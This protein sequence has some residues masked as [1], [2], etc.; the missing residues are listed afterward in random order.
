MEM[1]K[2]NMQVKK[3]GKQVLSEVEAKEGWTTISIPKGLKKEAMLFLV[4]H[5]FYTCFSEF[6]RDSIRRRLDELA[7]IVSRS[8][9]DIEGT[10]Q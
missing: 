6:V 5:P 1:E 4:K 7:D 3:M 10:L 2:E 8:A 9:L